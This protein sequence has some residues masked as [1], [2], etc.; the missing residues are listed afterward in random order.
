MNIMNLAAVVSIV[1]LLTACN[2]VDNFVVKDK[3]TGVVTDRYA[4][5]NTASNPLAPTTATGALVRDGKLVVV[6]MVSG[7]SPVGQLVPLAAAGITAE[8]MVRAAEATRPD[9]TNVNAEGGDALAIAEGGDAFAVNWTEVEQNVSVA[10]WQQITSCTANVK[11]KKG[12]SQPHP[13][14]K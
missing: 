11:D 2:S 13:S 4:V 6:D 9:V 5:M 7:D 12:R 14:C 8:G 1:G 3:N 10:V